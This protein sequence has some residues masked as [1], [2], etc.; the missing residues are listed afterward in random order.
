MNNLT[1]GILFTIS[2]F[3]F[4]GFHKWWLPV[5][6]DMN[7]AIFNVTKFKHWTIII[8]LL[9][10]SIYNLTKYFLRID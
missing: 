2:T 6:K 1:L 5:K 3:L 9:I 10:A 8:G 7:N 4:Y